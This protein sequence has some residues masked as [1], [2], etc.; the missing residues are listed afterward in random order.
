MDGIL[1]LLIDS[2]W[3]G[4][5]WIDF[6]WNVFDWIGL[7]CIDLDVRS[8]IGLVGIEVNRSGFPCTPLVQIVLY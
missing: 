4:L 6:D 3:F 5:D 7:R 2:N 1:L 8:V